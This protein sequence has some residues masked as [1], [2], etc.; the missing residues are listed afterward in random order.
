MR[1]PRRPDPPDP[2]LVAV[3]RQ[4]VFD[5]LRDSVPQ[6]AFDAAFQ[7]WSSNF[8]L[9][10]A[11][12]RVMKTLEAMSVAPDRRPGLIRAGIDMSLD[13]PIPD[14]LKPLDRAIAIELSIQ[15]SPFFP[16]VQEISEY[17]EEV[18]LIREGNRTQAGRLFLGLVGRD[19]VEWLLHLEVL[20]SVEYF[21]EWRLN[22]EI[23]RAMLEL[24]WNGSL[25]PEQV[26]VRM[27]HLGVATGEPRTWKLTPTGESLLRSVLADPPTPMHLLAQAALSDDLD[28]L[29]NLRSSASSASALES[30]ALFAH[31]VR[32]ALGPVR[33]AV[34]QIVRSAPARPDLVD[35]IQRGFDRLDRLASEASRLAQQ[36]GAPQVVPVAEAIEEALAATAHERNGR[37]KVERHLID[38]EAIGRRDRLV[39]ALVNL[40]RNAAQAAPATGALLRVSVR[41]SAAVV[42][43]ELADDGP[44]I[45]E[46]AVTSLFQPG[47]SLRGSTG[48]GLAHVQSVL[49]EMGGAVR[50]RASEGGGAT[51]EV[52][53][54]RAGGEP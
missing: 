49:T 20:R 3:V 7:R 27:V 1:D 46:E 10:R 4:H 13:V 24:D 25:A 16:S 37:L 23:A 17:A 19:A 40:I 9:V 51:F 26:L 45:P 12:A 48:L 30:T 44:G 14:G 35:R 6:D 11:T 15:F 47:F 43:V 41:A 8:E 34:D 21:D 22:A 42:H 2:E 52:T 28:A 18:G 31:E 53:L 54:R 32:N 38:A 29:M 33:A 36:L 5:R 50:Y 39:S